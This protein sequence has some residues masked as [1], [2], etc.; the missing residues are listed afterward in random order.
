MLV[1]IPLHV[2]DA[3]GV[4]LRGAAL[5][6]VHL[7]VFLEQFRKVEAVL[8]NDTGD[9]IGHASPR[10]YSGVL[11]VPSLSPSMLV[12]ASMRETEKGRS[13]FLR[14]NA[15]FLGPPVPIVGFPNALP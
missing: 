12:Y 6:A 15:L 1:R 3:V 10:P 8:L 7:T 5:S 2:M 11:L 14:S 4:K 9:E 13:E